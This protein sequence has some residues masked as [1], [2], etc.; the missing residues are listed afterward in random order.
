[1]A[2]QQR[3][4]SVLEK[5]LRGILEQQPAPSPAPS[6]AG[7]AAA[8]AAAAA[9]PH[10][11]PRQGGR[12][13][14]SSVWP[15][16]W[17]DYELDGYTVLPQVL[18]LDTMSHCAAHLEHLTHKF[19]TIPTEHLHHVIYRDDPWWIRLVSDDR[20]LDCAAAHA[21]FLGEGPITLFSSN[22]F[23]KMPHSDASVLWHQDG[24]YWALR[25]MHVLSLWLAVDASGPENGG[26]QVVKGSHLNPL[27]ELVDDRIDQ[28]NVLGARTHTDADLTA[29]KDAGDIVDLILQPGDV[30]IFHPNII[31]GS[32]PN[33]SDQRRA[34]LT[35]RYS[36]PT[37]ECTDPEQPVMMMRG[38]PDPAV[39]NAY[40]SWPSFRPGWDFQGDLDA[41]WNDR[42]R[43]ESSDP[44]PEYFDDTSA[45][46][47]E[48]NRAAIEEELSNFIELLGGR[49]V[50]ANR[51]LAAAGGER[52]FQAGAKANKETK[53][54]IAHGTDESQDAR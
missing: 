10:D 38:E 49:S 18:D 11:D 42:R 50:E 12:H 32:P 27:A 22:F 5:V 3:R 34:G 45:Q 31:H 41:S 30:A 43:I 2:Q 23:C 33:T 1:M 39:P 26:M 40:R 21:P 6:A 15:G 28:L 25:P 54:G 8:A 47:L 20:L 37:A 9:S 48:A 4:S 16:A 13:R 19:P 36:P 52:V 14:A 7:A 35:I 53:G 51:E 44:A 17:G 46:T 24:S 29:Y